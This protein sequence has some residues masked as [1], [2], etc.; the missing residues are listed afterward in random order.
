MDQQDPSLGLSIT[1]QKGDVCS[2]TT[3]D[4]TKVYQM[5]TIEVQCANVKASLVS[6]NSPHS[7]ENHITMKSYHGCP[8]QC[9]V[10]PNGLCDG[11]G[12]CKYD[13]LLKQPYC[14]C[15]TGR[16]GSACSSTTNSNNAM[17]G[18]IKKYDGHSVQLGLLITLLV[19]TIGLLAVVGYM[20]FRI[21][22]FR[23]KKLD[24]YNT[25]LSLGST[26]M[27][28]TVNF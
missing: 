6:A 27:V 5:T 18:G 25:S 7:C 1:Y 24:E 10:T 14:Y 12:Y 15:N 16:Y 9:L 28:D 11:H 26:E 19:V 20:V 13:K 8:T 2:T 23:K 17:T 3:L 22:D 4:K 21:T